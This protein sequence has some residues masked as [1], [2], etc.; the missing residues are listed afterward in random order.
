M[1]E[2]TTEVE[3]EWV[4][5]LSEKDLLTE[6]VHSLWR[7]E[8]KLDGILAEEKKLNEIVESEIKDENLKTFRGPNFG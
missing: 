4:Q 2:S 8:K 1:L 5:N 6:L 7:V 3:L